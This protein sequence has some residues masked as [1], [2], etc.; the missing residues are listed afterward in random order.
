MWEHPGAANSLFFFVFGAWGKVAINCFVL[1]TGYFMCKSHITVKKFLKLFLQIETYNIVFYFVFMFSGYES[2]SVSGFLKHILIVKNIDSGFVS[3]FI[4]F[5]L[6]IPFLNILLNHLNEKMHI[7]LILLC[8]FLYTF[9][10]TMSYFS[11]SVKMNYV[12]WFVVVYFIASYVRLYPRRLYE[13]TKIWA[14]LSIVSIV[15]SIISILGSL[16]FIW[17]DPYYFIADSNKILAIVTAFCLFMF[18]KNVKI[19]YIKLIN[20]VASASFGVLLIHANSDVMRQW[21]WRDTLNNAAVFKTQ[22]CYLHFVC[23]V[24][25]IY[26]ICTCI[27]LLRIYLLEKPFFKLYDKV[28][29][30]IYAR[31]Y[32]IEDRFTK[33]MNIKR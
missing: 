28:S 25:G 18:F 33:R 27:D 14:V 12:S 22:W 7:R 20:V 4:V 15:F 9:L 26:V 3:A 11:F 24:I 6:F 32:S 2:F 19:P 13:N 10:S 21:L 16:R 17:R 8:L 30:G 23:S 29:S 31:L 5:F 1:I